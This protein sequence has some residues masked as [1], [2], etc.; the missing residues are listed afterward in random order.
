MGDREAQAG[1]SRGGASTPEEALRDP[2]PLVG[3]DPGPWS[4]TETHASAGRRPW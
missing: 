1:A 2:T 3:R 4:R